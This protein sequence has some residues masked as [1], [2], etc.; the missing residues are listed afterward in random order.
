[1]ACKNLSIQ[2]KAEKSHIS[3]YDNDI[4]TWLLLAVKKGRGRSLAQNMPIINRSKE[5]CGQRR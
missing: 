1:M 5:P 4:F 3:P 2:S